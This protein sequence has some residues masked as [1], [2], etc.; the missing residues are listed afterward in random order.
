MLSGLIR[1]VQ[2][3]APSAAALAIFSL[4]VECLNSLVSY[5]LHGV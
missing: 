2:F 1:L 3:V 4:V 5:S